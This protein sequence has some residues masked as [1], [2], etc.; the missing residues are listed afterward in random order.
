MKEI[1]PNIPEI[2]FEGKDSKNPFA[3]HYYNP[4]QIILGKPMKEHLPFAMAWWHNLGA[5]G[6]DMF[7]AGPADKSFGA[8][9]GTMEHAK[10]KV[11]NS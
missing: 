7:G 11:E 8:K 6:V 10:A 4:D 2:K 5:T 3:F 9:V 1:F